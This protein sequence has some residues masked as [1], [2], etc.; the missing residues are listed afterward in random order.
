MVRKTEESFTSQSC[1]PT[2]ISLESLVALIVQC[3]ITV[4][5]I[6]R[7]LITSAIF[8]V[9]ESSIVCSCV[10]SPDLFPPLHAI[11]KEDAIIVRNVIPIKFFIT[12]IF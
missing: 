1:R 9:T 2:T 8:S 10:M 7:P 11:I 5:S 4:S 12:S 6:I 3:P